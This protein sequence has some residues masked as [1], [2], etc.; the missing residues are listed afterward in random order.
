VEDA[1]S[2][3]DRG[4]RSLGAIYLAT[5]RILAPDLDAI[6]SYDDRLTKAAEDAGLPTASPR[7]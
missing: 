2:E 1:V 3:P 5:A 7:D 6:V 4:L